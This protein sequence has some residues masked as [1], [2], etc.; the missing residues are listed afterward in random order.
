MFYIWMVI[1][2]RTSEIAKWFRFHTQFHLRLWLTLKNDY[3]DS[4]FKLQIQTIGRQFLFFSSLTVTRKHLFQSM[5]KDA[6]SC[7]MSDDEITRAKVVSS[8]QKNNNEFTFFSKKKTFFVTFGLH[9]LIVERSSHGLNQMWFS[10][11]CRVEMELNLDIFIT[12]LIMKHTSNESEVDLMQK[13]AL[14]D[15]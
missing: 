3:L 6:K 9:K 7:Q 5:N 1:L 11:E 15:T 8:F 10:L 12:L 4:P 13:N 2:C 14:H